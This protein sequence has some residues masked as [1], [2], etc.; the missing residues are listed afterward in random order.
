MLRMLAHSKSGG[1]AEGLR[2]GRQWGGYV[3]GILTFL[4]LIGARFGS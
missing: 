4:G 3:A 1:L 2:L